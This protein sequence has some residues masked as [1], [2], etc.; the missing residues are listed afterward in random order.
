MVTNQRSSELINKDKQFI[1][2]SQHTAKYPL[3]VEK[4]RGCYVWDLD[5]NRY[6]DFL[7]SAS[8]LN[9]G[10]AHPVVRRAIK[11]Q[12]R[13][14]TQYTAVYTYNKASVEYAEAL[15]A[16]YPG[17]VEVKVC[18]GHSGSDS[19]DA[20]IKFARAYT[21]RKNILVL[22][23]GYHGST[24]GSGSLT[25]WTRT[26]YEQLRPMLP[27]VVRMPF[28]E[29]G[30]YEKSESELAA[31]VRALVEP[32]SIAA[33]IIE[34][35]QGDSGLIPADP[36]FI[37]QLY[38]LCKK[39]GILFISE[40][41][42]QGFYRTGKFFSI[43]HYGIVPDGIIIGKA[44]GAGLPLSAFIGR[45]EVMDVLPPMAHL[46]TLAANQLSCSAGLAQ[47][48]YMRSDRFQE[49]LKRN[50]DLIQE[51]VLS[52]QKKRPQTV[53]FVRLSG[54]SVGIGIK[55]LGNKTA[56]ERTGEIVR[57]C[58]DKGLILLSNSDQVLRIQPPLNINA[59]ILQ[60][61]FQILE[62]A[63]IESEEGVDN[64]KRAV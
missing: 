19:N 49:C 8:S 54:M 7:A 4:A 16:V 17:N 56:R 52:L 61:G 51:A 23:N 2:P 18:F 5:G 20:A 41:V 29:R 53:S 11:R 21:G 31:E 32:E 45:K 22:K 14:T 39:H 27:G 1:A 30:K 63:M 55:A 46:F 35:I 44:A 10:S 15:S 62:K 28:Y 34:P 12:L 64:G 47:L 60:K 57:R 13:K 25:S 26:V 9:L 40:E 33:L 36:E 50:L 58:F 3:V 48:Q 42:Q 59:R 6:I 38:A 37:Q 43:E 24:Y